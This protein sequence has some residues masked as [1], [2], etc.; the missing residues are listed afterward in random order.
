M[1]DAGERTPDGGYDFIVVGS[2]AAGLV[3]AIS[4]RL[5]G[6]R[7]LIIEK[8]DQWGGTTA[9]SGGVLWIPANDAMMA[10]GVD[11][12]IIR[13]RAYLAGL[14]GPDAS[15]RERA[16]AEA[17]LDH[18]PA[19]AR[20]LAGEGLQWVRNRDHPDYYPEVDGAG[21]GR[22]LEAAPIDGLRLGPRLATLRGVELDVPALTSD[23]FGPAVLTKTGIRPAMVGARIMLRHYRDKLRG[24][25]PLGSGR[26]LIASLMLIVDRLGIPVRLSTGLVDLII[27]H[28]AVTGV[29][30]AHD[31]KRETLPAP[32]GVLLAAGGFAHNPAL[33][34][35]LQG[36]TD[37]WSNASPDDQGDALVA[38]RAIGAD[39]ELLDDCWWMPT[40]EVGPDTHALALGLRALPGSIVVDHHGKRY[41]DEARSYMAT[42]R[43]MREHGAAEH[44][45]WLIMDERFL[46]RHIFPE[47]SPPSAR[48]AMMAAGTLKRGETIAELAAACGLDPAALS[49]TVERFNGFARA[50]VDGDFHRGATAYDRYWA[51]PAHSPNPSLGPIERPPFW[52]AVLRPGDLGTNGGVKTDAA[53]RVLDGADRP[54]EGLYAAGNGSGSP[55]RRSYPGAGATIG[56][57]ATYGYIA[58]RHAARRRVNAPSD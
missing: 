56:A 5:A 29:V 38:A 30:V 42:G 45:H 41:M 53:G 52:A 6:L 27:E 36:F 44:R 48:A 33:R 12:P 15:E 49:A 51:D 24:R 20:M 17:F 37:T 23:Q 47:L 57:A 40:L 35:E 32:A 39:T 19:M 9:L 8:S 22:T 21:F 28:G 3:G 26:G 25:K 16:K 7:P 13:A 2:G 14:L 11:D 46:S 55:F 43:I 54:I 18:A 4:A 50:G 1:S 58:A 34:R 10:E 31:G